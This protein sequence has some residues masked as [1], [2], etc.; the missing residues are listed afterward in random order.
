MIAVSGNT[1]LQQARQLLPALILLDMH[2][3]DI[4]GV[5]VLQALKSAARTA[6]IPVIVLSAD[7]L[8]APVQ[9]ARAAGC[10]DYRTKPLDLQR[11]MTEW[12]SR[13]PAALH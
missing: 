10:L 3:P 8:P 4:D 12:V 5:I 2:L 7:A 1:G 13:F 9:T 11:V 6:T